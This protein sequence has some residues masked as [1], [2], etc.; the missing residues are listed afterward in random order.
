MI[1]TERRRDHRDGLDR[2]EEENKRPDKKR[3]EGREG[4]GFLAYFNQVLWLSKKCVSYFKACQLRLMA[5]ARD[6]TAMMLI[7]FRTLY[8]SYFD[9]DMMMWTFF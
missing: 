2:S 3:T 1:K 7:S 6:L 5:S 8:S 4:V 9:S